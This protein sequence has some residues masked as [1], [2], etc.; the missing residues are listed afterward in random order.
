MKGYT[1]RRIGSFAVSLVVGLS[2]LFLLLHAL[3]GGETAG[4]EVRLAFLGQFA[5]HKGAHVF[6]DAVERMAHRLPES[7]ESWSAWIYGEGVEGRHR[8]YP[9]A[10]RARAKSPRIVFA[11]PFDA[12]DAAAVLARVSCVVVPSLWR[13]NAPLSALEARAAGIPVIASDV[14]GLAEIIEPGVHGALFPAGD[15]A[16]LADLLRA[17][18]L[19]RIAPRHAPS[20]PLSYAEHVTRVVALYERARERSG[21]T[22][23]V[24]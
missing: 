13:E 17:V 24:R 4:R 18:V 1:R 11:P 3:P 19:G 8:L 10:L 6:I 21:A 16:A 2:A 20:Q 15:S 7:V 9:A 23:P 5:P 14:P 12:P 22:E